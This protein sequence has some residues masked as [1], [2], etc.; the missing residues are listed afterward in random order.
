LFLRCALG[1]GTGLDLRRAPDCDRGMPHPLPL[2]LR[3]KS[4][5]VGTPLERPLESLRWFSGARRR[6]KHPELWELYLEQ[7]WLR[8]VLVRLLQPESCC[9]DIG[10]HIG[11]FTSLLY[12]LAPGGQHIVFEASPIKSAW[13][14]RQFPSVEVL[15]VAVSDHAGAALFSEDAAHSGHSSLAHIRD[16]PGRRRYEVSTCRLDDTLAHLAHIDFIKMDIEGGELDALRGGQIIISRHRPALLFE[17]AP[18]C[19]NPSRDALYEFI[20]GPLGYETYT[21][22]DFLFARGPLSHDEYRKCGVYP[23][24]AFNYVALPAP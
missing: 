15:S 16:A 17:S 20:T 18:Y 12:E 21:F 14:K 4:F 19:D 9:I 10:G 23:F 11:S 22:A 6:A 5:L 13:I 2:S 7:K 24:R 1:P 3:I 8:P